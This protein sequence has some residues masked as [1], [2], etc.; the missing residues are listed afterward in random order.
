MSAGA[1][2]AVICNYDELTSLNPGW[3]LETLMREICRNPVIANAIGDL[4]TKDPKVFHHVVEILGSSQM[5][6]TQQEGL[7]RFLLDFA[8]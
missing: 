7:R 8:D 1:C 3:C 6:K 2:K 4:E 5:D